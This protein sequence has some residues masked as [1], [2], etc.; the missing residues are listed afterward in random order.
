MSSFERVGVVGA[1]MMGSEIALVFALAGH[2]T[3]PVGSE[4]ALAGH[5]RSNGCTGCSNAA[6]AEISGPPR[7]PQ[8]RDRI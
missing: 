8:A 4:R 3:H 2:P 1:G 7:R 5:A 6:S